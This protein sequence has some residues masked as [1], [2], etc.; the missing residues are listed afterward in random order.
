MSRIAGSPLGLIG[1]QSNDTNGTFNNYN[2][3]GGKGKGSV[4]LFSGKRVIRPFPIGLGG[5]SPGLDKGFDNKSSLHSDDL[6][7][8]TIS[9][10]VD[11]LKGTKGELSFLDFAYLK[12]V[13]VYPNNRLMIARRFATPQADNI[14]FNSDGP[15]DEPLVTLISW[16]PVGEDFI[17]MNFGEKW[18]DASDGSFTAILDEIGKDFGVKGLGGYLSEGGGVLPLPGSTETLQRKFLA[19]IGILDPGSANQIPEGNPNL[20]KQAKMRTMVDASK[21]GSGLTCGVKISMEC[22]WEQKYIQGIDPTIAWM[23]IISMVTRFG[24]STSQSYGLSKK[25]SSNIK[26]LLR[27]PDT[28][29]KKAIAALKSSVTAVIGA[30]TSALSKTKKKAESTEKKTTEQKAQEKKDKLEKE[31]G[32]IDKMIGAINSVVND[33]AN[34]IAK[35][36]RERILGVINVLSGLPSTPWHITVGNPLRPIFCSGDMVTTSVELKLGP[37]LSFND[38]PTKITAS[39][40]L[41]NSKPLGLQDILAKFNSGYLRVLS[42]GQ[43]DKGRSDGQQNLDF[44]LTQD[45]DVKVEGV[46]FKDDKKP[47][48]KKNKL[49]SNSKPAVPQNDPV[50]LFPKEDNPE[51]NKDPNAEVAVVE[52]SVSGSLPRG[53][54]YK[55]TFF[56][57]IYTTSAKFK[58]PDTGEKTKGT[59]SSKKSSSQSRL[60]AS[61]NLMVKLK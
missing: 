51:I 55:D 61:R 52:E 47:I 10:I 54:V 3:R 48:D 13:G 38:L 60:I 58:D 21:A 35:K 29:V 57:G 8:T 9:N 26:S 1:L 59:G 6:Y 33:I 19:K 46:D 37:D 36:Y 11:K 17:S 30:I 53:V 49:L 24:T 32:L 20:I 14:M 15:S 50:D 18:I 16:K 31:N 4:S 7:N 5:D 42:Y 22:V 56:N 34:T 39:F 40:I 28:L 41:E 12:D 23:D 43:D 25:L 45:K 2:N 27:N 44:S